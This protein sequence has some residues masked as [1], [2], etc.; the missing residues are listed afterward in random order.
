MLAG[1]LVAL[2]FFGWLAGMVGSVQ[3]NDETS[4]MPSGAEST[5]AVEVAQREFGSGDTVALVVVYVR[6]GGLTE[7]DRAVVDRDRAGLTGLG[8]G[9]VSGPVES[10]G[11]EAVTLTVPVAGPRLDSGEVDDV[12]DRARAVVDEGLPAALDAEV[13]GPA[14]SRTDAVRANGAV[15]SGLTVAAVGVVAIVLLVTY[16]S[17]LLLAVPLLCVAAGMVVAQGGTYLAGRAGALVS[18]SGSALVVVLVFG[19]GTDYALLLVSRYRD[20]LRRH[21][22]RHAAMAAALRK[23]C[24]AVLASAATMVL[25]ALALLAAEMTSTRGLGP[26]TVAA[27]IAALLAMTTLLPAVLVATGRWVFW[28]RVPRPANGVIEEPRHRRWDAIA[29]LVARRPRRVWVLTTLV[30]V[31]ASAGIS[32]LQVG[33]L[34]GADSFTR[35]PDSVRGQEL[36]AAHFP[37]GTAV[38]AMVYTSPGVADQVAVT[39]RD[40]PG[41]AAVRPTEGSSSGEWVRIPVVLDAPQAG[42]V[43]QETIERLRARVSVR[44][45]DALV[46][47]QAATLLDQNRAMNRDLTVIVPFILVVV[48]LVL[49]LLLRAV[50]APLLLLACTVLSAG[51][52]LGGAGLLF[53]ALGFPRTDQTVLTLGFLFLVALG[54]DYT[55]FL[56][57]R[58]REEVESHGHRR[59]VLRALTTTGGVITSAGVVLAATFL[60]LTITPVVLNI[61]LGLLVALGVVVDALVVR[62]LLVPA[63][64]V[65]VGRRIWWPGR[66]SRAPQAH[67]D[68]R[69]PPAAPGPVREVSTS[70]DSDGYGRWPG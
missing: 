70:H 40:T 26:V 14:A 22:D 5:R 55:I 2:G 35:K 23:V 6:R 10:A 28:P 48:A 7:R 60:V 21:P 15:D 57:A 36:L 59:G 45:G 47:G 18:G 52:A 29:T 32:V 56:M 20:E 42:T 24:P 67:L 54:I 43:A 58:A 3:D 62:V 49:G 61:Q 38:P 16:R 19:L 65:W 34:A 13:T 51:A 53:R 12:V 66:L 8:D 37:A 64:A 31:T 9:P 33:T 39:A 63:M 46:G 69:T 4:W 17:P 41:V 27:V 11:R 30:L 1:W 68:R 44:D 50:L 25:A